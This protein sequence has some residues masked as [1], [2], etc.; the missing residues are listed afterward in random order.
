MAAGSSPLQV[1]GADITPAATGN[2]PHIVIIGAG[3]GGL[4]CAR[5]LGGRK[6]RV[7]II[8]RNNYHL[9]VPLLYQVATAALS[10][11]DIAEPI[12]K[13]VR[14]HA[15]IDVVM[16]EVNGI[17]I[18]GR[19][20]LVEGQAHIPYDRLVLATGS[21]YNYFG[22]QEWAIHAPGLKTVDDARQIRARVL[23]GFERAETTRDPDEQR[24]L[25]TSIIIGG[26]PTGVEMA[27]AIAEL[28]RWSLRRDFRNI[29]PAAARVILV[30]AGPKILSTFPDDLARYARRRLERLGVEV[31]VGDKVEDIGPDGA[32]IA[33]ERIRASNMVWAAGIA[34]S[35]AAEWIGV[36]ADRLG[37]IPVNPDL[38]VKGMEHVFA[39]GDT[40]AAPDE[41]GEP[42][43]GLAQVAKQQGAHLG[44]S[45][46]AELEG[47]GAPAPFR[48]RDRGNTA[49]IGR[50]AAIFDFGKRKLK[51]WFAWI[52]WAVV[53]VYLLV[54]FEQRL[55]VGV[56]WC[57][58]W[59]TYQS[60][61]RLISCDALPPKDPGDE[62]GSSPP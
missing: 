21:K 39:I 9:F 1:A 10:P 46:A 13:L 4:A 42:L 7:T 53:H 31:R 5:A 61:A 51:G 58:R 27:G 30:E 18:A 32:T 57:L 24:R 40:A 17:D 20:V 47:R 33:G 49:V 35:P 26:G 23:L 34:A 50:S 41:D 16:G 36:E 38:S 12:R 14:R 19:R 28:A 6:A 55:L 11:S 48:F 44:K 60:G 37:R 25:M 54:A 43:P 62:R 22:N 3:F 2:R 45:L 29:D 52:L 8:D 59:F 56:K 15:N